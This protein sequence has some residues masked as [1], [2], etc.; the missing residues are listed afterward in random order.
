MKYVSFRRLLAA[1]LGT[2][3]FLAGAVLVAGGIGLALGD[4]YDAGYLVHALVGFVYAVIGLGLAAG[5]WL[6]A[7][8]RRR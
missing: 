3:L 4:P 8:G 2:I 6:L 7:V 5:G 1:A